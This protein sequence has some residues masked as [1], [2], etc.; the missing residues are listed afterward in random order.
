MRGE[1]LKAFVFGGAGE[2]CN[3]NFLVGD[4]FGEVPGAAGRC[5]V[6]AEVR[7][8]WYGRLRLLKWNLRMVRGGC[9]RVGFWRAFM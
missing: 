5:R 8:R 1:V 3:L 6:E 2:S 7:W 4:A 9:G